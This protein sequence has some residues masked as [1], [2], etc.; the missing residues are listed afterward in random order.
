MTQQVPV[1]VHSVCKLDVSRF[2]FDTQV[3]NLTFG[4]WAYDGHELNLSEAT[5]AVDLG[6]YITHGEWE[7]LNFT[8]QRIEPL[9]SGVP[10]PQVE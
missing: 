4:S 1:V 5:K 10:Y 9:F 7:V 3:C 8:S 6:S 2:P